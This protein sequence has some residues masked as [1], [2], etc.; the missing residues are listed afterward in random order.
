[1]WGDWLALV[2]HQ[3]F[4]GAMLKGEGILIPALAEDM[5]VVS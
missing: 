2:S 3:L 1:M 5:Q 4:Y